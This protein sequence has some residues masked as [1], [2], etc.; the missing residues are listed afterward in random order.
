MKRK[1][2]LLY[3][4]E[5]NRTVFL[6]V[7]IP[8]NLNIAF[9]STGFAVGLLIQWENSKQWSQTWSLWCKICL[10]KNRLNWSSK[11]LNEL[12]SNWMIQ[13]HVQR[14]CWMNSVD[15]GKQSTKPFERKHF[16]IALFWFHIFIANNDIAFKR[17][18]WSTAMK[19]MEPVVEYFI[20]Q[21]A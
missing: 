8:L 20:D 11:H 13:T 12:N 21:C 5:V 3:A 1:L 14:L 10:S 16:A 9:N 2:Y 7:Y 15:S 19:Q 18:C 17:P 6:I 4:L